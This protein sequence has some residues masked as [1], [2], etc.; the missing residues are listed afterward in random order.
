VRKEKEIK[1][2][3][4]KCDKEVHSNPGQCKAGF[5]LESV[6]PKRGLADSLQ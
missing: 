1:Y 6:A 3:E 2:R 5:I 4:A